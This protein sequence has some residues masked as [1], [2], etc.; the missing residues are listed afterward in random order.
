MQITQLSNLIKCTKNDEIQWSLC[1]QDSTYNSSTFVTLDT[2]E[3]AYLIVRSFLGICNRY[4]LLNS[5]ES[6][7]KPFFFSR[8]WWLLRTLFNAIKSKCN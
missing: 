2:I 1:C 6:V 3:R 8:R 4:E 7:C 5:Q